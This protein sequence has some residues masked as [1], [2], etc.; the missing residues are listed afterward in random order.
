MGGA[1]GALTV[2]G[3]SFLQ[4]ARLAFG[5]GL[6]TSTGTGSITGAGTRVELVGDGSSANQ[7]SRLI[8]GDWG[9]GHL[10]VSGGALVDTA[11]NQ[12]PCLLAL[13]YCDSF[14]GLAAGDT[15]VLN[16]TG[17][18]STVRTGQGF[19]VAATALKVQALDGYDFG[20]PGGTTRG[21]VNITNGGALV[22][23]RA[24]V[25]TNHWD[26]N[27]T[28]RE[29]NIGEVNVSG[30]G[31][32]WTV[33]SG[34]RVDHAN[35]TVYDGAAGILTADHRNALASIT[36][37]QG[38]LI[39]IQGNAGVFN[40]LN[41]TN[42]GGHTDMLVD[43]SGSKV[44]FSGPNGV[45]QVGRRLG[46]ARLDLSAGAVAEGMYF[47]HVGRDGSSGTMVVDGTGTRVSVT[48]FAAQALQGANRSPGVNVGNNG[49]TGM[50][51]VSGGALLEVSGAGQAAG[52]SPH[53]SVGVGSASNGT[54]NISG[55]GSRVEVRSASV[56]PGGG[57]NEAFAAYVAIGH[58]GG[59]VLNVTGGG[60]LVLSSTTV[61]TDADRRGSSFNVGGGSDT[62]VG[63]RGIAVVRGSGSEIS[64]SGDERIANI[65]RGASSFGQL[66]LADGGLLSTTTINVGRAGALGVLDMDGGHV[67]QTGQF[68]ASNAALT[69]T[70]FGVGV[71][72]GTGIVRMTNGST[73]SMV[74]MGTGGMGM[75]LGGSTNSPGGD[76]SVTMSGGSSITVVAAPG[77]ATF[78]V[79][80]QGSGV[81]RMSGNSIVDIGDGRFQVGRESG[82]DGTV[83]ATGGS[84]ITA[85]SVGV[86]RS[87]LSGGGDGG[88]GG[89]GTMVLNGATLNVSGD[90]IIGTNG[91]LG[92]SAGSINVGGTVTNYGIFAP[93]SSPGTFTINGNFV[94]GAGSRLILEVQSDGQGSFLT[95]QVIFGQG[96]MLDLSATNV[97]FRFLGS[98]DPNAFQA[99]GRFDID[100]FLA[101]SDGQGG[102]GALDPA[103]LAGATFSASADAYVF[104]SFTFDPVAGAVFQAVPVPEPGSWLLML[105]GAAALLG[106]RRRAVPLGAVA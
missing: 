77:L 11:G 22:T 18:G 31:S 16:V 99:A 89:T 33:V 25:A 14:V 15:A 41:L 105:G 51:T 85:G 50:L 9:S 68:A 27:V 86:G 101:R 43:G 49:G 102:L 54:L 13:H 94:A 7:V 73:I 34:N 40:F 24:Q 45:L 91:F 62:A 53:L 59:G 79:G 106:W 10:T 76:G 36:V 90:V 30:A 103:L 55:S 47:L 72:G 61:S 84:V 37:T 95:D 60:K 39:D 6:G 8:V 46:T 97:E 63:A 48:S 29:R 74:N 32:R 98:T 88:D 58:S 44:L 82:S 38:G 26:P 56:A 80:R 83:I 70:G 20:T 17:T 92:G 42:N 78:N 67:Q 21:T 19:F 96:S 81:L 64:I 69:S 23:D 5:S 4:L 104:Q 12:A 87:I 35:G 1:V 65:G 57:P 75:T 71:A 52:N 3:G 28:G 66:I 100:T 2:D 93:G